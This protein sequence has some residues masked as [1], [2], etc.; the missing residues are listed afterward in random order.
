MHCGDETTQREAK[1]KQG[2]EIG[3]ERKAVSALGV[4]ITFNVQNNDDGFYLAWAFK[5]YPSPP[6][7][8]IEGTKHIAL[9]HAVGTKSRHR[10]R[11]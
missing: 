8:Q 6:A 4:E 9:A 2:S 1:K 3:A 11:K 7:Q 5:R 10:G